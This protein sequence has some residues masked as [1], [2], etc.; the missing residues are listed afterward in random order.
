[1]GYIGS[2]MSERAYQAYMSGDRPL[3]KWSKADLLASIRQTYG[4]EAEAFCRKF[5]VAFLKEKFLLKTSWHHTGKYFSRTSFYS[6]EDGLDLEDILA[7]VEE[8]KEKE[9][10]SFFPCIGYWT[11][12]EGTR[13]HPRPIDREEYGRSD[14]KVFYSL[15]GEKKLVSGRSF[16]LREIPVIEDPFFQKWLEEMKA[17]FKEIFCLKTAHRFDKWIRTGKI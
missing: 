9:T 17:K 13:K 16:R 11:D 4:E 1:M 2:R 8:K 7:F 3:S 5:S 14:G 12:W 6:F 10:S 15:Y